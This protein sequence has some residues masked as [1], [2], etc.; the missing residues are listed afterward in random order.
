ML[1]RWGKTPDLYDTLDQ[2]GN[3]V[4]CPERDRFYEWLE[5]YPD[6]IVVQHD[7]LSPSRDLFVRTVFCGSDDNFNGRGLPLLWA[8]VIFGGPL[9]L[10]LLVAAA[11]VV[12]GFSW[13]AVR[14]LGIDRSEW[15]DWP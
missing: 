3:P 1:D 10:A 13:A 15:S 4:P 6:R 12:I 5:C 14:C 2:D 8:T 7:N 11:A 9:Q